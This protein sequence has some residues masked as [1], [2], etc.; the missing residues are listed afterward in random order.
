MASTYW[1][2][3]FDGEREA[4]K[5]EGAVGQG[6]GLILRTHSQDGKGSVYLEGSGEAAQRAAQAL[7]GA[8]PAQVTI[9]EVTRI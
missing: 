4:G 1:R 6:G 3:D 9:D 7:G 2:I 8:T 5:M